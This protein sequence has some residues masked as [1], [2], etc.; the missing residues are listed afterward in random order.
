MADGAERRNEPRN[1]EVAGLSKTGNALLRAQRETLRSLDFTNALMVAATVLMAIGTIF[2]AWT[3]WQIARLTGDFYST[4]NRPYVGVASIRL[5]RSDQA[6]PGSWIEFRNFANMPAEQTVI[7]VST[8]IN[9]NVIANTLGARHV[10]LSLGIMSPEAPYFFGAT[11]PPQYLQSI[12]NG[13]ARLTVVVKAT[14]KDI[15]GH[16]HC[17]HMRY[18]Y[19]WF[20]DKYDPDGG[21]SACTGQMP[22]YNPQTVWDKVVTGTKN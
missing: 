20:F 21:G 14:Y 6:Q 15:G 19:A 4:S 5:N 10:V 9:G 8:Q 2:S 1:D 11:F 16:L 12:M 3:S 13:K 22:S 17:Y 18:A 7:D